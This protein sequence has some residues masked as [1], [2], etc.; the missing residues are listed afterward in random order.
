MI[1]VPDLEAGATNA[2]CDS[3]KGE[4]EDIWTFDAGDVRKGGK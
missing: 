3:P 2:L 4:P 1:L